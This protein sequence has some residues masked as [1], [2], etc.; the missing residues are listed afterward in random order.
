MRRA[1]SASTTGSSRRG[2]RR[3]ASSTGAGPASAAGST[4]SWG[5]SLRAWSWMRSRMGLQAPS[6]REIRRRVRRC[7]THWAQRGLPGHKIEELSIELEDGLREAAECG[8]GPEAVLGGGA[9]EYA[10]EQARENGPRGT[11]A[12]ARIAASKLAL[13]ALASAST[14]LIPQ[15]ALLG[16]WRVAVGWKEIAAVAAIFSAVS[17]LQWHRFSSRTYN[18]RKADG[19]FLPGDVWA[20]AFG[21]TLGFVLHVYDLEPARAKL[22]EWPWWASALTLGLALLAGRLYARTTASLAAGSVAPRLPA[23][24]EG[25][26]TGPGKGA[27]APFWPALATSGCFLAAWLLTDGL[28]H[29]AVGSLLV[30]SSLLVATTLPSLVRRDSRP[31]A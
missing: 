17:L 7:S 15:H 8:Y 13:A 22:V 1:A 19:A 28:Y 11:R 26:P 4:R 30:A 31:S 18:W 23:A 16:S 27:S 2:R 10:E 3:S 29:D 24:Q 9:R 25:R 12:K 5:W 14:V 6:E 21:V 20:F